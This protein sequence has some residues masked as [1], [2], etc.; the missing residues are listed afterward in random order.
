VILF[1]SLFRTVNVARPLPSGFV[2]THRLPFLLADTDIAD[3]DDELVLEAAVATG[4]EWI[5][6]HNIRDMSVGGAR[7]GVEVIRPGGGAAAP[8][9]RTMNSFVVELPG[10]LQAE[11]ARHTR[12]EAGGE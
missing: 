7:F 4:S 2:A 10:E 12:N 11:V 8:G 1:S 6:T 9:G 3:P 5:V